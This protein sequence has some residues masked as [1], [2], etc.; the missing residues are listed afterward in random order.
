MADLH[1]PD[2]YPPGPLGAAPA[3][4]Y[5]LE[6]KKGICVAFDFQGGNDPAYYRS[7]GPVAIAGTRVHF[8][9]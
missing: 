2:L 7:R 4:Y 8:K 3:A 1:N 5:N 9:Y 6:L